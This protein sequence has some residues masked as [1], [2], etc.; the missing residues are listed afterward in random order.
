M[1]ATAQQRDS[2][3]QRG[4]ASQRGYTAEWRKARIAWLAEHPLCAVCETQGFVRFA[5]V[6]DHITPHRGDEVLFWDQTN[7]QSL[8]KLCH[9]RKTGQGR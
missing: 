1:H 8:C 2:D 7:W 4:N 5:N 6:V 9:D 3:A